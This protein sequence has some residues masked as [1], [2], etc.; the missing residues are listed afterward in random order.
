MANVVDN[1]LRWFELHRC[2]RRLRNSVSNWDSNHLRR[3]AM[4]ITA[5]PFELSP[6]M[7]LSTSEEQFAVSQD[8]EQA[9][10]NANTS[11]FADPQVA[12]ILD[13]AAKHPNQSVV[14]RRRR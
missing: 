14:G 10:F 8:L 11:D 2:K 12:D 13:R 6:A 3:D 1:Y 9:G 7:V 4:G 5:K